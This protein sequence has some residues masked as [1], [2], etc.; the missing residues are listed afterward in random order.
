MG[1]F[2]IFLL[3][4]ISVSTGLTAAYYFLTSYLFRDTLRVRERLEREFSQE[5]EKA[6]KFMLFKNVDQMQLEAGQGTPGAEGALL[7]RQPWWW[8]KLSEEME[9][10][11]LKVRLPHLAGIA[12]GLGLVLG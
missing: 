5:E 10:C 7:A 11:N 3:V 2:L 8:D 1:D 6:P 4:F 9:I 12:A